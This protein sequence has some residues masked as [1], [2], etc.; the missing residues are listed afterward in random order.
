MGIWKKDLKNKRNIVVLDIGSQFVKALFLEVDNEKRKGI[1]RNWIKEPTVD[2]ET[3]GLL[4]QKIINKLENKTGIKAEQI[5]LG[6]GS[7]VVKGMSTNFCYK[8]EN[9]NQKIDLP[10]IKYLTQK[11]QWKALDKIRKTFSLETGL[12]EIEAKLINAHIINIKINGN[13]IPNPL[14]FQGENLCLTIFNLY[15]STERLDNLLNIAHQTKLELVGINSPSC[16]L[17]YSLD[18]EEILKGSVLFVDI[19]GKLTEVTLIKNGGEAIEARS[20][21]L[22]GQIFTKTL[23]NFLEVEPKEAETIKFK[24]SK[25]EVSSDAKRKLEKLFSP[26]ISS[27][28]NGVKFVL[29]EFLRKY[30]LLPLKILLCG[31]GSNLPGIKESLKKKGG[32]QIKFI[33]PREFIKIEN[34][35]KFQEIPSLALANLALETKSTEFSSTLKRI[36]RLIQGG[37]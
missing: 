17:F 35:T 30:K 36:V 11:V 20:F 32:F 12:K 34:R 14:G 5:F 25:G 29:D 27:W 37:E 1:L 7:E 26:D 10:E 24:Y 13:S 19:G 18:C 22:G 3:I 23:S 8:R 4:C 21:N 2:F 28:L 6:I 16:A 31:G 9:P 15:T 33:S